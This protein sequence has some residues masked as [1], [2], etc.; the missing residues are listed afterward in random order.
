MMLVVKGRERVSSSKLDHQILIYLG[1]FHMMLMPN[2]LLF[3]MS[4]WDKNTV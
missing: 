3:I 2:N 1:S 4:I